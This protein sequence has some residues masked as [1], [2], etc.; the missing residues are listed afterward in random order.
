L[1]ADFGDAGMPQSLPDGASCGVAFFGFLP[2]SS[3][4][5]DADVVFGGRRP[6]RA[7]AWSAMAVRSVAQ[8]EMGERAT[9]GG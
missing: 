8:R 7:A 4:G 5:A 3:G 9:V 6:R 1:T 2:G